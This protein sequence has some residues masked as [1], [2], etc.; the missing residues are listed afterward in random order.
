MT[1]QR[2][3]SGLFTLALFILAAS[4]GT[5]NLNSQTYTEGS[6]A[7]TVFDPSG[8]VVP[9][10]AIAIHNDETNAELRLVTDGSGY[11]KAPILPAAVYTVTVNATGFAPYKELNV[12][13]QVGQTTEIL[14]HLVTSG[15]Q[16]SVEVTAEAPI[17]NFESPDIST[18]LNPHAVTDLPLNGGRWSNLTL[19]TP[20]A[21]LDTSGYG[22][23]SFRAIST[24]LNNVEVDGADD[25]QAYY[26]EERGRTREGYST[27]KYIIQEFQVNTGVYSSEFGRSAGGVVN[28]ITKSGTNG[29]HG[30]L[31][32]ADRDNRSWGAYNEFTTNTTAVYADGSTLPTSFVT[33]PYKPK[34]WRK[35]W[36][37]DVGGP[38]KKNKLFWF[39]GY[40]EFHRN[41]PGTAKPSSPSAFFVVPDATAP[42]GSTC[43]TT[44]SN[45]G[46][47]SGLTSSSTKYQVDQMSCE[48]AAR[49]GYS[50][51][52][53]GASAYSTQL[54]NL[55]PDLGPVPRSGNN[56]LNTPKLDWQ[57][58][59]KNHVSVLFHR[60]SWDSPGG[61]QTQATNYYAIDSFGTDFVK[62]DYGLARLDSLITSNL[63]NEARYQYSR[64]LNDEG[65]QPLSSYTKQY[66]QGT[67]GITNT[68]A[69]DF[70]PNAVQVSL[71]SPTSTGFYLGSLYYDYRKALPDEHKWQVGDTA[72]W[73]KGNHN[74]KFGIDMVNNYDLMANTYEAN[75]VYSYSYLGN[76]FA[77]LLNE[78]NSSGATPHGVCNS[79]S[80]VTAPPTSTTTSY[81][82]AYT[83]SA[84]CGTITQGFGPPAW[85]IATLNYGFFA[86]DHWKV[87]PRLTVDVGL[88]YDYE[89]LPQPYPTLVTASGSF[90][91]YLASTN[92]LCAVYTG[93]G[94]CPALAAAANITNHPSEKTNFGPRIGIAYDPWGNGKTTVR[95]GYGLYFGPIT[96][97]VL[98]N[99]LLN[100]GSPQGQYTATIYPNTYAS[101]AAGEP[102]FPNIVSAAAGAG[103]P[104]SQFFS[105]NFKNPQVDE[106]DLSVQRS[107]GR[108]TVFQLSYMGALGRELPNAV[109]INLNPNMNTTAYASGSTR[110]NGVINSIITVSDS[111][112]LG[113]IPNGTQ[114][115][116]PT[117]SKGAT[118]YAN[119]LNPT[120]GSVNE[121][122]SNIN[123]N[124]NAMVAE[125]ENKSSK[126]IQYDVNY[127]WSH[128][129]DFN[130]N[131]TTTTLSNGAF[132][133]YNIDGFKKGANY[134]NSIYN[135]P[136]RLVAWAM[137]NSPNIQKDNWVKYLVNDWSLNPEFQGQN[138]LPYSATIGTGYPSYSA[139]GSSWNGAGSNYWIPAL[140]RNTYKQARVM[141]LDMRL[142]KQFPFEVGNKKYYLQLM[143]EFFNLAN[144]QNVTTVSTTA[145][146]L[147]SYSYS[148]SSPL[149]PNASCP[150]ATGNSGFAECSTLTYV[151]KAGS[152]IT[153]SGFGAVT[154]TN[155]VYMYTPREVELTLRINF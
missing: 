154:S 81:A 149:T 129:L 68:A 120:Y 66:L 10:A 11:F 147:S 51:Y 99:N 27:S 136:S 92:G 50:T 124:Y 83:G 64:E 4:I 19:L 35:Q 151:P 105:A 108:G 73:Q 43:N 60:L 86:E 140:G 6:I 91:P 111:S 39:Y 8:A 12:I 122:M 76:Y 135:I 22:L 150:A 67:N 152:G 101:A 55:L 45:A 70:S 116:V 126:L 95:L 17:L 14:P 15:T 21:T 155:N 89:T 1:F 79:V 142:E 54:A 127:T 65:Q 16:S 57:V 58:N 78:S 71:D 33:A 48:L 94:T 145:Y 25:N 139:Y 80:S 100:T 77:D 41:F 88:R 148:S 28:S 93:P 49:L 141:V 117:Y 131:A 121:L 103:N 115:T 30:I 112:G 32:F 13:V 123:S 82:T 2:I 63:S 110:P 18:V 47:M 96:N 133:P 75:G 53:A 36:G 62:L 31:Y 134:G 9:G 59:N 40:N 85:D 87:T 118:T 74:I 56:L 102:L 3:R 46:Y 5:L 23:I 104:T 90:T 130:Q 106:F 20:G 38:L 146:N 132:D 113:P 34:D 153:A 143:G 98:L 7:G 29:L 137:I 119:M 24:I 44:G 37:F 144:H 61:V 125:V 84:P 114:F 138:G 128:A 72:A 109:N 52:A 26:A 69:G 107:I 42:A 97:G